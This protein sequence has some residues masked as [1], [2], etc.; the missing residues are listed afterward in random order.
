M[1]RLFIADSRKK[2]E[3]QQSLAV[4]LGC[5]E[6]ART[7][8]G[9]YK[10]LVGSLPAIVAESSNQP[11]RVLRVL[12]EAEFD[13]LPS[14]VDNYPIIVEESQMEVLKRR[15]DILEGKV[16]RELRERADR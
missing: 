1:R 2:F 10:G 11:E 15:M 4:S 5:S 7:I 6:I 12:A 3:E 13:Q 14:V 16:E 8:P 9:R